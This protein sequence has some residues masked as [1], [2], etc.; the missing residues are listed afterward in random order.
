MGIHFYDTI[1]YISKRSFSNF[2]SV[3]Q[4]VEFDNLEFGEFGNLEE[5]E[6]LRLGKFR[7]WSGPG[8]RGILYF[9]NFG[10]ARIYILVSLCGQGGT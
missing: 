8:R 6:F 1:E 5:F 2:S 4:E 10:N 7:E 9:W 3:T